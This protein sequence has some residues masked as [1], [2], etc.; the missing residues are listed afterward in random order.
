[1]P[2]PMVKPF[3]GC[4]IPECPD[5][6]VARGWCWRHYMRWRAHGDPLGGGPSKPKPR[7]YPTRHTV[8]ER[9]RSHIVQREDGC[10][11]W[12]G[13]VDAD[14][15][16]RFQL[17]PRTSVLAH[18]VGYS[19]AHG[20]LVPGQMLAN[21]CGTRACVNPQHWEVSTRADVGRRN[22]GRTRGEG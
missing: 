13:G 21:R 20:P 5:P 9:F 18:R 3:R 15:Y 1:M 8:E 17:A 4:A 12:T 7:P 19:L 2:P 22:L 16:G 14:G 6:H 10:W 11:A